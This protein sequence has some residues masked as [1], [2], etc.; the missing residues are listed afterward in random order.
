MKKTKVIIPALGI[1]LLSTAAS[2]TGT[3]AWFSANQS[4]TATGMKVQAKAETGLLISADKADSTSWA[5]TDAALYSTAV[6]LVPASTNNASAWY[7]SQSLSADNYASNGSYSTLTS[8]N[9]SATNIHV[10]TVNLASASGSDA[11]SNITY[12]DMDGTSGYDNAKDIGYYLETKFWLKSSGDAIAIDQT[13]NWLS[14]QTIT[15]SG[16]SDSGTLDASLRIG[17]KVGTA[18]KILAPLSAATG[19]EENTGAGTI[20]Y[21]VNVSTATTTYNTTAYKGTLAADGNYKANLD[22]GFN[23]DIPAKTTTTPTVVSIYLWFEG[24]DGNCKSNNIQETLD[25]LTVGV[26]FGVVLTEP[27]NK[28]SA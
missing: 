14:I 12:Q 4:V 11:E 5:N 23:G 9:D 8:G 10:E 17:V 25:T 1:L 13:A 3:V 21:N 27:S 16:L 7:H 2:V 26:E 28:A 15:L 22:S 6:S 24:E 18:F 19:R 20:S